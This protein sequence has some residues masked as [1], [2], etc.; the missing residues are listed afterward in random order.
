M[1]LPLLHGIGKPP[2][3]QYPAADSEFP[4]A[5]SPAVLCFSPT[6]TPPV[7]GQ[8]CPLGILAA[9]TL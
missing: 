6:A 8:F 4:L 7:F 3:R 9:L 1:G 2:S 5:D